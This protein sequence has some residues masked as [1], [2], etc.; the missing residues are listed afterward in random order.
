MGHG[1]AHFIKATTNT[2][3]ATQGEDYVMGPPF[4]THNRLT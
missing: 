1:P 2:V 3:A 4:A